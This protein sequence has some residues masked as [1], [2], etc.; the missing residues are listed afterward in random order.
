MKKEDGL[1]KKLNAIHNRLSNAFKI[2][3]A[4]EDVGGIWVV[5]GI[6]VI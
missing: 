5:W 4:S 2:T 3:G 1:L 6:L